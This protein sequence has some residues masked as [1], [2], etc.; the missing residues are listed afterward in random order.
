MGFKIHLGKENF[1]FSC[2]HFTIFSE[3]TAERLHGH[4][5]Q[6]SVHLA[7][8][9]VDPKLGFAFDFNLVKPH[10]KDICDGLDEFILVPTQS[11]YLKVQEAGSQI[12]VRF[13]NKTYSFPKED[14]CLVPITNISAEE[15]AKFFATNLARRIA[16][17]K[18]WTAMDV[19]VEETRGQ[20]VS[21]S[22]SRP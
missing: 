13:H 1:K 10:I 21:Y 12:E 19:G 14:T 11:P 22:M 6:I 16:D 4:N 8:G 18:G 15:L 9:D 7:V 20:S 17:I 3:K 5:Y 2:S